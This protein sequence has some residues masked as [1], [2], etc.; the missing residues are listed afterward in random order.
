MLGKEHDNVILF[1]SSNVKLARDVA[2][3][4]VKLQK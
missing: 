3:Q 1:H 2:A 4:K